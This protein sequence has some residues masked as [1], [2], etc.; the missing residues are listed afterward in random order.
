LLYTALKTRTARSWLYGIGWSHVFSCFSYLV[1]CV[2]RTS[3]Y[4][5]HLQIND[6]LSIC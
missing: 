1:V 2:N 3:C 6:N 5:T 4:T